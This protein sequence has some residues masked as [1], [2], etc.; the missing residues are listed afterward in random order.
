MPPYT[1]KFVKN[2]SGL[3]SNSSEK[4]KIGYLSKD[5]K[6]INDLIDDLSKLKTAENDATADMTNPLETINQ[7]VDLVPW[8]SLDSAL[9]TP[10]DI[11]VDKLKELVEEFKPFVKELFDLY[12]NYHASGKSLVAALKFAVKRRIEKLTASERES[13]TNKKVVCYFPNW[14]VYRKGISILMCIR[15]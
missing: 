4:K 10:H 2:Q 14:T 7:L 13:C 9:T 6:V 5:V 3:P 8:Q 15:L 12:E 11:N 1:Y